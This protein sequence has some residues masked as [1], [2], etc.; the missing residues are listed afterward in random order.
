MSEMEKDYTVQL[1]G[2]VTNPDEDYIDVYVII[3]DREKY[4]T[5]FFTLNYIKQRIEYYKKTGENCGGKYFW[6]EDI[7][8]VESVDKETI[9]MCVEDMFRD[10]ILTQVFDRVMPSEENDGGDFID[11]VDS[12]NLPRAS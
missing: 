4:V 7:C 11:P 1:F 3:N 9:E 12:L 10:G 2:S 5:T 8:I 6:Y